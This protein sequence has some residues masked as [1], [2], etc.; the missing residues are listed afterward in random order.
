MEEEKDI[1]FLS[2]SPIVSSPFFSSSLFPPE[3]HQEMKKRKEEDGRQG[4]LEKQGRRVGL[5][6][7]EMMIRVE[8]YRREEGMEEG[9]GYRE[10]EVGAEE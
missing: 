5:G 2:L 3:M 1:S 9:T 8:G 4:K 10:Q 6:M 7:E